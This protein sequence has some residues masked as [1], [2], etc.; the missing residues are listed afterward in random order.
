MFSQ[1]LAARPSSPRSPGSQG[2]PRAIQGMARRCRSFSVSISNVV[3]QH[4]VSIPSQTAQKPKKSHVRW[5]SQ[6]VSWLCLPNVPAKMH[7]CV[8]NTINFLT[9]VSQDYI[10]DL[11]ILI[12]LPLCPLVPHLPSEDL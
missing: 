7:H 4:I 2:F 9:S 12:F 10:F 6:F 1:A 5:C 11:S 8:A 3:G